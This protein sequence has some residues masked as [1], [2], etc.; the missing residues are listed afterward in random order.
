MAVGISYQ[1]PINYAQEGINYYFL[2]LVGYL[3]EKTL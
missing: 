3:I 2:F 1:E